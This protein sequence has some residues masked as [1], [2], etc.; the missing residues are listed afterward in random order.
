MKNRLCL[1]SFLKGLMLIFF[2]QAAVAD[3]DSATESST[4]FYRVTGNSVD[5]NT[6]VGYNVY[7][8]VCVRCHGVGGEGSDFAPNLIDSI[9]YLSPV[10]FKI[11]VLHRFAV[12]FSN[13]DRV[14][15]EQAM[16]EEI[17]KQNQRDEGALANM[18]R[19]ENN[20]MVSENIQNIYRYLKARADGVIGA[21][22]P[23]LLKD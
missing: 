4:E 10:Q 16:F 7:H 9:E 8:Q 2:A 14:G 22:K 21:D 13:E 19:W 17:R 1:L 6:F 5:A 11:K 3:Q 20:P 23:D 12:K 15:M 18:P